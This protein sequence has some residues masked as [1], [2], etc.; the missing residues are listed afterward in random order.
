[1]FILFFM[2][3]LLSVS[4]T[5]YLTSAL[6]KIL[7]NCLSALPLDCMNFESS[8]ILFFF[9]VWYVCLNADT[10]VCMCVF[11]CVFR[12]G[13]MCRL[14]GRSWKSR[15]MSTMSW[16]GSLIS[17]PCLKG[18]SYRSSSAGSVFSR[19]PLAAISELWYLEYCSTVT[20]W[21][22]QKHPQM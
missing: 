1:M 15:G 10:I 20:V 17:A 8:M 13:L 7:L 12:G 19:S 21:S 3:L 2:H 11:L 16:R 6:P 4:N 14:S 9:L 5:S 18:N 22:A